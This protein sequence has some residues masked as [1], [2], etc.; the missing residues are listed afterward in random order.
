ML[1][2]CG[3]A[4]LSISCIEQDEKRSKGFPSVDNKMESFP[5]SHDKS[6]NAHNVNV[7]GD[8]MFHRL[9]F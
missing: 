7:R 6:E 2:S 1:K 8:C 4:H 9:S 5:V 3:H